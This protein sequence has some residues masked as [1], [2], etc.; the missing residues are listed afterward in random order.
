MVAAG[1]NPWC[2]LQLAYAIGVSK[3]LALYVDLGPKPQV[4][5]EKLSSV[6]QELV[7]LSPKGIRDHLGLRKPIYVPTSA[8]GHF[9]RTAKGDFFPW[10][11]TDLVDTLKNAFDV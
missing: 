5:P 6:L 7:N 1:L 11:K 10:E 2:T 3:P 8:Y 9:G 4:D